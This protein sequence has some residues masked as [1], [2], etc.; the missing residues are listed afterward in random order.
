MKK[1]LLDWFIPLILI[2]ASV[3]GLLLCSCT[4]E[5]GLSL[6]GPPSVEAKVGDTYSQ[7]VVAGNGP[8][9]DIRLETAP[10][11]QV[12]VEWH[13]GGSRGFPR[14]AF[15]RRAWLLWTGETVDV[16]AGERVTVGE[17][18]KAIRVDYDFSGWM[19][20]D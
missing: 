2:V 10:D 3:V 9:T 18:P 6:F 12:W 15:D 19:K 8:P 17:E 16:A 13:V 14:I 4:S 20:V 5:P 1:K 7:C 11:D